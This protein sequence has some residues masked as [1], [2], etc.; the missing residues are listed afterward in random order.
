PREIVAPCGTANDL[1]C[2]G[3]SFPCVLKPL[4]LSASRG[5]IRANGPEEFVAAFE[6]I[7]HLLSAPDIQVMREGT[8]R[9]IQVETYLDGTEIAVEAI[10]E[11][12]QLRLLAVFD[13]P[14]PL[15]GPFFEETIYLTPSRLPATAESSVARTLDQA[16]HALGLFH[17]P[18]HAEFRINA[19]GVWVLEVAARSIGGLCS[20]ALRFHY[21]GLDRELSLEEVLIRLAMGLDLDGLRREEQASGVMMIPV[22]G[23][24]ILEGV[25]GLEEALNVTGIEGI[26]ITAK[27]G[28]RLVPLPEGS[29]YPGFIFARANSPNRAEAALRKSHQKLRFRLAPVL[30]VMGR[31]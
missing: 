9:F 10:V 12:G 2:A 5:V 19:A 30:P 3:I 20:R 7:R 16:V 4:A 15:A 11:R 13:K 26:V 31:P 25:D 27:P 29:S 14:D 24:G 23:E 22:P 21:P 18:V 1:G 17:G 6:R 8:S 28:E